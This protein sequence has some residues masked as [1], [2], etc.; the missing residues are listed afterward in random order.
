MYHILP[1]SHE[2]T[3][4]IRV[5]GWISLQDYKTLL[6]Y[7]KDM[8]I[9]H[10][11]IRVLS[12]LSDYKGTEFRAILKTLPFIF[13]YSSYVEKR[14]VITDKRWVYNWAKFLAFFFKTEVRCFPSSDIE[15]AWEWLKK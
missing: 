8:I 10:R 3:I 6:P 5:N 11:N 15:R 12:D 2:N 7:I 4:G 9:K 1:E 13:K 14:A